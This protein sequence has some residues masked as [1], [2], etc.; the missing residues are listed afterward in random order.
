MNCRCNNCGKNFDSHEGGTAFYIDKVSYYYCDDCSVEHGLYDE[1][2]GGQ[3]SDD[4]FRMKLANRFLDAQESATSATELTKVKVGGSSRLDNLTD[5]VRAAKSLGLN[6]MS[7]FEKFYNANKKPGETPLDTANRWWIEHTDTAIESMNSRSFEYNGK[8]GS[9]TV[10]KA[11]D[12]GIYITSGTVIGYSIGDELEKEMKGLTYKGK[13]KSFHIYPDNRVYATARFENPD[14]VPVTAEIFIGGIDFDEYENLMQVANAAPDEDDWA[15]EADNSTSLTPAAH[16]ILSQHPELAER[17]SIFEKEFDLAAYPSNPEAYDFAEER[18]E[19]SLA[20][21]KHITQGNDYS[22]T[23]WEGTVDPDKLT[24]E[25]DDKIQYEYEDGKL[26]VVFTADYSGYV[27]LYGEKHDD[28]Y[29][30]PPYW[31][32]KEEYVTIRVWITLYIPNDPTNYDAYTSK[33][34]YDN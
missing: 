30:E 33:V 6:N 8:C 9:F 29:Y 14:K 7:D 3:I 21:D 5:L 4:K 28:N 32:E 12:T 31:D 2:S 11:D 15:T 13:I 26:G 34:E 24:R 22:Y 19:D 17:I 23:D 10:D 16:A 25:L 20:L 18:L 1:K 27:T